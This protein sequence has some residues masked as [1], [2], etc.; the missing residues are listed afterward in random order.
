MSTRKEVVEAVRGRAFTALASLAVPEDA[1]AHEQAEGLVRK[2][3]EVLSEHC[4]SE[5]AL[6]ELQAIVDKCRPPR[7]TKMVAWTKNS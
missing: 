3:L 6:N 5:A 2:A 4:G 1:T 7:M